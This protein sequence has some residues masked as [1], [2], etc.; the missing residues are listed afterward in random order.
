MDCLPYD[1]SMN[2]Q[3]DQA[4][5]GSQENNSLEKSDA[6]N[7]TVPFAFIGKQSSNG[8]GN[9]ITDISLG[10]TARSARPTSTPSRAS[11]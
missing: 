6:D 4:D 2:D 1:L 3:A 5:T 11:S 9:V 7:I 8:N 10:T